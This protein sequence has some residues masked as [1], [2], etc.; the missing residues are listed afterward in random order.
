[1]QVTTAKTMGKDLL[2]IKV[3]HAT[4]FLGKNWF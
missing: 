3:F 1:V 4:L 2:Q